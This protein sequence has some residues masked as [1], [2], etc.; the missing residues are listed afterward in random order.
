MDQD[1]QTIELKGASKLN[2]FINNFIFVSN[3]LKIIQTFSSKT[4]S[5]LPVS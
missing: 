1:I 2:C 5:K 3:L 4:K